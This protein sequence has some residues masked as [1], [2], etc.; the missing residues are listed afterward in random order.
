M[1]DTM[2]SPTEEERR[3][4]TPAPPGYPQTQLEEG[5]KSLDDLIL[6]YIQ[7]IEEEV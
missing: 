2:P 4:T 3:P 5:G 1:S 7:N 6:E